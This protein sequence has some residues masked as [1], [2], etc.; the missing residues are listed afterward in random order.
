MQY[1]NGKEVLPD[2]LLDEIQNYIQGELLYIPKKEQ[3]AGWGEVNG[4]R[5]QI[6]SRNREIYQLYVNGYTMGQLERKYNLALDSIRK[7]IYKMRENEKINRRS[8]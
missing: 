7:I 4:S 5:H 2:R 8:I 1:K 3:R 6:A